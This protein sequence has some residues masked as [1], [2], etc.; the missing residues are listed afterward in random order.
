VVSVRPVSEAGFDAVA[1]MHHACID[2]RP[3]ETLRSW[4]DARPGLFRGAYDRGDLVGFALGRHREGDTAELVGI[5]VEDAYTR[6]GVG[7][8]LLASFEDA[9]DALG[10]E[11]VSLGSAGG[12][13]DEFYLANGYE[14][15]S[16][17]V[18]TSP[19]DLPE[20]YRDR[21]DVLRERDD[22]GTRKVY[23]AADGYDPGQVEAVREAFDDP[24]AVYIMEKDL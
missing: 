19:G 10:F 11:R 16:V 15:E 2:D 22:D 6:Q 21:F 18:R 23:V 1:E 24:E 5:A 20:N 9:A 12:Y 3:R 14:P 7:S 17:L 8:R 13:V 4:Y